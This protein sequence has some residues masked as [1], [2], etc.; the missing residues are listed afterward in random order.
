MSQKLGIY[1]LTWF[2]MSS[3]LNF[4]LH[5]DGSVICKKYLCKNQMNKW[6]FFAMA[7]NYYLV[8]PL[9][10]PSPSDP[11]QL[12]LNV[13]LLQSVVISQNQLALLSWEVKIKSTDSIL[14]IILSNI[15]KGLGVRWHTWSY[16]TSSV[17]FGTIYA[18]FV[19][20]RFFPDSIFFM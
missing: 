4:W 18:V 5:S 15:K 8:V 19:L 3:R 16:M 7:W 10:S 1:V 14:L 13:Y 9:S 17:T 2:A 12:P 20:N 11:K 6:K